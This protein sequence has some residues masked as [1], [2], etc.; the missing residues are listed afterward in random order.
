MVPEALRGSFEAAGGTL[1]LDTK[2]ARSD[3]RR[4][5]R[6]RRDVHEMAPR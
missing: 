3:V 2:V 1:M 6:A 5:G 4:R